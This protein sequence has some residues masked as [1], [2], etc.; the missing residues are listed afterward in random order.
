MVI[1]LNGTLGFLYESSTSYWDYILYKLGTFTKLQIDSEGS[2]L[3]ARL[4][5]QL[6]VKAAALFTTRTRTKDT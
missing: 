5:S 6:K 2:G 1:L 3:C 4:F